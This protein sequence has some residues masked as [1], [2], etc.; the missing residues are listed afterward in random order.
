MT[1][2]KLLMAHVCAAYAHRAH[3]LGLKPGTKKFLTDQEAFIEG[4][5][6]LALQAGIMT[7]DQYGIIGFL[8]TVGRLPA[9]VL[10]QAKLIDAQ[11]LKEAA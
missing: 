9:Y 1:D 6:R 4:A 11:P 8:T 3:Q 10:E 7:A 5:A 2:P